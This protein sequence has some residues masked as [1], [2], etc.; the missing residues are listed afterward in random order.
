MQPEEQKEIA[1]EEAKVPNDGPT[2]EMVSPEKLSDKKS[3]DWDD[4]DKDETKHNMD[5]NDN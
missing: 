3:Q 4:L 2:S 1:A 5:K